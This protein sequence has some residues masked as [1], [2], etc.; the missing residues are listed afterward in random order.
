MKTKSKYRK[1]I[2]QKEKSG[3]S[4][5]SL[6]K[7]ENKEFRSFKDVMEKIWNSEKY[8]VMKCERTQL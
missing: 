6:V 1:K 3:K 5:R 2:Q 7:D 4:L 8:T